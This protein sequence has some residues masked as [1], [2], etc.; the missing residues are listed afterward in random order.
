[1]LCYTSG[2]TGNPKGVLYT[3]RSSVIHALTAVQPVESRAVEPQSVMLPVVPMFHAAGLGPAL[4]LRG[5]RRRSWSF[6]RS[7]IRRCCAT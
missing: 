1:M 7:T 5:G 3:H 2:T 6:R 4:G